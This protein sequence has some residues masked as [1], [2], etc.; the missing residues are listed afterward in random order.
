MNKNNKRKKHPESKLHS[1]YVI[2]CSALLACCICGRAPSRIKDERGYTIVC[3]PCFDMDLPFED[4][5]DNY[6]SVTF[7]WDNLN[8]AVREWNSDNEG[9]SEYEVQLILC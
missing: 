2:G 1:G 6:S 9:E 5:F 7:P 3:R 4:R 8:D